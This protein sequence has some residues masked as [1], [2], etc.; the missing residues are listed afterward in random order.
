MV[1]TFTLNL[2]KFSA[3][4]YG[5]FAENLGLFMCSFADWFVTKPVKGREHLK[6]KEK[7][8]EAKI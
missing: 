5:K 8:L 4:V 6:A 1:F 7:P 2:L 3:F